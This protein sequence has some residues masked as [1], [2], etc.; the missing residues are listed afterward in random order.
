MEPDRRR[1]AGAQRPAV[2]H[3][4]SR[5]RTRQWRY[6]G[7]GWSV[8]LSPCRP[9]PD[10]KSWSGDAQP[11]GNRSGLRRQ[12]RDGLSRR[13]RRRHGA[14]HGGGGSR[15][16]RTATGRARRHSR[17]HR[18][19]RGILP[20]PRLAHRHGAAFERRRRPAPGSHLHRG[21]GAVAGKS[22]GLRRHGGALFRLRAGARPGGG[23]CRGQDGGADRDH[24]R[25]ECRLAAGG[26]RP[27]PVLPR[28]AQQPADQYRFCRPADR[29]G[30]ARCSLVANGPSA[31]R[32]TVRTPRPGPRRSREAA[33]AFRR[34]AR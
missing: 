17:R 4:R 11:H 30:G 21:L 16:G 27:D 29:L 13:H 22:Q 8:R 5:P 18:A 28:A 12:P 31:T 7:H 19:G 14:G 34:C 2:T 6:R 10:R 24:R 23:G 9:C 32:A 1:D 26:R 3:E 33:N 15:S 25:R 20:L